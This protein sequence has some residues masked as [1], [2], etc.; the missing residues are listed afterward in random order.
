MGESEEMTTRENIKIK[1]KK[2]LMKKDESIIIQTH[3]HEFVEMLE[4]KKKKKKGD[5]F[6]KPK[7]ENRERKTHD[8]KKREKGKRGRGK[9]GEREKRKKRQRKEKK[10]VIFILFFFFFFQKN[11]FPPIGFTPNWASV[12]PAALIPMSPAP[13]RMVDK[14]ASI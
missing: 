1:I 8:T 12:L 10:I 14:Q 2:R 13:P 7:E 3:K 5:L 4:G 9:E 11:Y 6:Q